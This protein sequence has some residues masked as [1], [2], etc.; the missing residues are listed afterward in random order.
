MVK[1]TEKM[2]RP[3]LFIMKMA[4]KNT[5]NG[6]EMVKY[7]EKRD[8]PSFLITRMAIKKAKDGIE[9]ANYTKKMD[10]PPFFI[11]RME[12]NKAKYGIEMTLGFFRDFLKFQD[13]TLK[14]YSK[15]HLSKIRISYRISLHLHVVNFLSHTAYVLVEFWDG[16]F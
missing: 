8:Q 1:N 12:I 11:T 14:F 10:Q 3:T 13:L 5:T 16:I 15:S 2:D 4:T 7:T 9:M 6:I